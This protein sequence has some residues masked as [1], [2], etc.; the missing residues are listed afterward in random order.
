[1]TEFAKDPRIAELYNLW[2][3]PK[4]SGIRFYQDGMPERVPQTDHP[5][6]RTMKDMILQ[7]AENL[8]FADLP[9]QMTQEKHGAEKAKTGDYNHGKNA[10][11][12][13]A[14]HNRYQTASTVARLFASLAQLLYEDSDRHPITRIDRKQ[15]RQIDEKKLVQGMK[16]EETRSEC[17]LEAGL[18]NQIVT[19]APRA[20]R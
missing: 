1:M 16:L 12:H 9:I 18:F 6:F 8:A 3:D 15:R 11:N 19:A 17:T 4:E 14:N 20:C 13:N 10:A 7:E 2:Y 5:G